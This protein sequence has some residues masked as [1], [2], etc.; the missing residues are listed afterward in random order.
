MKHTLIPSLIAHRGYPL[1]YPENSL[2]GIEAA[3]Q[4]GARYLEIDIQ[5]TAEGV[6]VLL[7]DEGLQRTTGRQGFITETSVNQVPVTTLSEFVAFMEKWPQVTCFIELKKES[8]KKFGIPAVTISVMKIL[9]PIQQQC[10]PISKNSATTAYSRQLGAQQVGF[11][12]SAYNK[13]TLALAEKLIPDYLF[14]NIQKLP[15]A[16]PRLWSGSWK[17]ALYEVTDPKLALALAQKG[18]DFIETME[19]GEMLK[20]PLLK[21]G[22]SFENKTL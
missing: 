18:A 17:W 21:Q 1:H 11:I 8:L 4:T 22:I 13:E 19:I 7:H 15:E 10:I 3:L 20:H 6:P 5:L 2:P 14:C 12:L 9:K 16:L